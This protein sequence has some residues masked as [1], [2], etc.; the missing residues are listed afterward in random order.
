MKYYLIS[1]ILLICSTSALADPG[2]D[3]RLKP[4]KDEASLCLA[5]AHKDANSCDKINNSETKFFCIRQIAEFSHHLFN[6]YS[7]I[8]VVSL[9]VN[10]GVFIPRIIPAFPV[11][12]L[13]RF[14]CVLSAT[15][16]PSGRFAGAASTAC[17]GTSSATGL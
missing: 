3:C 6:S 10:L 15:I 7:P 12:L 13:A 16:C 8:Q 14:G 5:L 4:S 1:I 2:S 9:S 17:G 11:P